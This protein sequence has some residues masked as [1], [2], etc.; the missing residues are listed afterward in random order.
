MARGA[1]RW[2]NA[3]IAGA[4][5]AVTLAGG[6]LFALAW[7]RLGPDSL[8]FAVAAVWLPMTWLGTISQ[9]APFR[10]PAAFHALRAGERDGRLQERLGV[11]WVKRLLRRGPAAWWNPRLRLPTAPTAGEL[12]ALARRMCVAEA[13]HGLALLVS[14][15]VAIHAAARAWWP[16]A[17]MTL[18]LDLLI[19]GYPMLLQRYNRA[20][21]FARF[22]TTA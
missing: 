1:R 11:R 9:V 14:L 21:L 20:R 8:G 4:I 17:A 6:A 2:R 19:N 12:D 15:A 22:G 13:S 5:G 16:A 3:V 7:R 10:L 18:A